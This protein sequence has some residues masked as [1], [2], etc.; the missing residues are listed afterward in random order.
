MHIFKSLTLAL[1]LLFSA[2]ALSAVGDV[3][4]LPFIQERVEGATLPADSKY[5][6]DYFTIGKVTVT[7]VETPLEYL[8]D[9]GDEKKLGAVIMTIEKLIAL[10]KKIWA[11]V[12]AG[13]PVLNTNMMV[14]L[15][16]LPKTDDP[17]AAFYQME[18]W[19]AP[20]AVTYRVQYDNLFGMTVIAFDYT[21]IFQYAGKY[22]GKGAYI[23]GLNVKAS[24]VSVAWGFRFDA[25][26]SLVTIANR[27]ASSNPVAGATIQIDYKAG[28]VLRTIGTSEAFHVTGKGSVTK[29]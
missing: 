18:G 27:G 17:D 3:K 4:V 21:V 10:G 20:K 25:N 23:T 8:E 5:D 24:N 7:E 29:Y 6:E 11:I 2:N 28:S 26:S 12:E 19:S 9:K 16:V 14:P 15:S 1:F 22:E 13:R